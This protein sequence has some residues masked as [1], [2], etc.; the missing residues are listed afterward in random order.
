[1]KKN[2]ILFL[3]ALVYL[4]P[5]QAEDGSRLWLPRTENKVEAKVTVN[6]KSAIIDTALKELKNYWQGGAVTLNIQNSAEL[7]ELGQ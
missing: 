3:V 4:F 7:R 2:I 5:L 1:M 6:K